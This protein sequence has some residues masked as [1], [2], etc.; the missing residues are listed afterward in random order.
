[1]ADDEDHIYH[2]GQV[3]GIEWSDRKRLLYL[4]KH[5]TMYSTNPKQWS[6]LIFHTASSIP[7]ANAVLS[8][9][10]CSQWVSTVQPRW[11][12]RDVCVFQQDIR[13]ELS[14]LSSYPFIFRPESGLI[15]NTTPLTLKQACSTILK[16]TQSISKINLHQNPGPAQNSF[17]HCRQI[18][19]DAHHDFR[20]TDWPSALYGDFICKESRGLFL[21]Q[22]AQY[23][24]CDA[25]VVIEVIMRPIWAPILKNRHAIYTTRI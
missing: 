22:T 5:S 17:Y 9:Y 19:E 14:P 24:I 20:I 4:P 13:R 8:W 10:F 16:E 3:A 1:M 11:K 15:P 12:A 6:K 7:F 21:A 23:K 2:T 25:Y 18:L